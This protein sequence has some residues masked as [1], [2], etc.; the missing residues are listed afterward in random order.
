MD[1]KQ[2]N[3]IFDKLVRD[4][5]SQYFDAE[6]LKEEVATLVYY[7]DK[8]NKINNNKWPIRKNGNGSAQSEMHEVLN[9]LEKMELFDI[10]IKTGHFSLPAEPSALLEELKKLDQVELAQY[11]NEKE[12]QE[13]MVAEE[14]EKIINELIELDKNRTALLKEYREKLEEYF[15]AYHSE[16]D[17]LLARL[18]YLSD[19]LNKLDQQIKEVD[20]KIVV[21]EQKL[22]K[23]LGIFEAEFN[24]FFK[25]INQEHKIPLPEK[26]ILKDL[27]NYSTH[28][29]K[30]KLIT[31][32]DAMVV[33]MLT[34]VDEYVKQALG[35]GEDP[36]KNLELI[37]EIIV[38]IDEQI[39]DLVKKNFG[40]LSAINNE[41]QAL[42]EKKVK[43]TKE[44][45]ELLV[46]INEIK[47]NKDYKTVAQKAKEICD[48]P[49][50]KKRLDTV[51]NT[52]EE[53]VNKKSNVEDSIPTADF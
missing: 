34:K 28:D 35:K 29:D 50:N 39:K 51:A 8:I 6:M 3:G 12:R 31:D 10:L 14:N 25:H 37:E 19:Q 36:K 26:K 42:Q 27:F 49:E 7:F 11:L 16:A 21:Q 5:E 47:E 22:D 41:L 9:H 20:K 24:A 30:G 44:C 38:K 17:R 15:K 53:V 1:D 13:L 2:T 18:D 48:R 32:H 45:A 43:L 40:K 4:V 46:K 52:R 23:Q 33:K